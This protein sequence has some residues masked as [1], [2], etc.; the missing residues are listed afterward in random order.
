MSIIDSY[1]AND[2]RINALYA[3][4]DSDEENDEILE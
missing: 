3:Y 4:P 2:D 1:C